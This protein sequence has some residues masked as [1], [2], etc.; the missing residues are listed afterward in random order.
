ML[1][2]PRVLQVVIKPLAP[3]E[4]AW[5][6][7]GF[8]CGAGPVIAAKTSVTIDS[9]QA[10][11]DIKKG[12]CLEGSPSLTEL[13]QK[14][15]ETFKTEMPKQRYE[16]EELYLYPLEDP[17]DQEIMDAFLARNISMWKVKCYA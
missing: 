6:L 1:D 5:F 13:S 12:L 14:I 4:W 16:E 7:C 9:S 17:W 15:R 2:E 3:L 11:S 8:H 10:L